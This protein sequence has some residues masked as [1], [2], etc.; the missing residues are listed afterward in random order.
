MLN[1]E[2]KK[3]L[4]SSR[5]SLKLNYIEFTDVDKLDDLFYYFGEG[6]II[7]TINGETT[8]SVIIKAMCDDILYVKNSLTTN[9][10]NNKL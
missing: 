9:E 1:S 2:E 5:L 3:Y 10:M 7:S 6:L 8:I 4:S